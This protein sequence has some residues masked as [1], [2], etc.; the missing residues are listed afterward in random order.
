MSRQSYASVVFFS[1]LFASVC[2]NAPIAPKCP[3]SKIIS[4]ELIIKRKSVDVEKDGKK[5]EKKDEFIHKGTYVERKLDAEIESYSNSD[6]HES[7]KKAEKMFRYCLNQYISDVKIWMTGSFAAG[8]DTFKSD[9][10]FTIKTSRWPEESSFQKLMKIKGFFIGNSLFKTGRVVRARTPV[11]K[12]VHLETDVEI[13]VTMDNEDSK[14]NTQLLSWYSQMDNRFSKLCRA[15]KGW[16]SESGIEG[17]K[18]GRLNSFSI[19]LMLIQYLQ[20]LNILPNIQEFFPELN[21]PIEIEDDNYG[22]R[23]MKK[24]IQERGYKFEENE[25]SLSD[26]YFGFLKFYAE[27]NF[28]KSWISVKNGK[29][30]E[31]RFDETEKPLDGLPDSHHFIVV[32]DPFLT[33]PRNCGGSVQGSCFVERIQLEFKIAADR[34]LKKK[35]LFG[36]YPSSWRTRLDNEGRKT[37][38][39]I[40]VFEKE[41]MDFNLKLS[42]EVEQ[43]WGR[44]YDGPEWHETRVDPQNFWD[45]DRRPMITYEESLPWPVYVPNMY[46]RVDF[47]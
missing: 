7:L 31:K 24:E 39:R 36:G 18:N 2:S 28:D 46:C 22:R 17:A 19:C 37:D 41:R 32:E 3:E 45:L 6:H 16:A 23:D 10:D 27:F 43:P 13:D 35:T 12:L 44:D 34:I 20:T 25:R 33:T 47:V 15:I 42:E 38:K 21:G 1:T 29:I 40:K 4:Q 11:L 26:L 5:K 14:R 9:L 30:M 8:V